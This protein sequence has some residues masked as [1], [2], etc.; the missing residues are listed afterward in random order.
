LGLSLARRII[1]DY[2]GGRLFIKETALGK[3]TV[4]RI[5]L[6]KTQHAV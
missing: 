4:M 3:G 1:E 6:R 5:A 2:H